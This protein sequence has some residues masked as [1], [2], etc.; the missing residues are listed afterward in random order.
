MFTFKN[1]LVRKKARSRGRRRRSCFVVEVG[2]IRIEQL[3]RQQQQQQ[4]PQR[5]PAAADGSTKRPSRAARHWRRGCRRWLARRER[6]SLGPPLRLESRRGL[7]GSGADVRSGGEGSRRARGDTSRVRTGGER[8]RRRSSA[9]EITFS[10]LD[11]GAADRWLT[12]SKTRWKH[13][14]AQTFDLLA[15]RGEKTSTPRTNS[16]AKPPL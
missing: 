16:E 5:R 1:V 7:E 15:P 9:A 2:P 12:E 13:A 6:P 4:Q 11:L 14:I 3:R 8:G 10:G